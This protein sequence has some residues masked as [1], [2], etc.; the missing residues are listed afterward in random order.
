MDLA[1][2]PTT[3][4]LR[5]I[6]TFGSHEI[7]H[8]RLEE[9]AAERPS[10]RVGD[11]P[12]TEAQVRRILES[13][14]ISTTAAERAQDLGLANDELR[15]LVRH[16]QRV[17]LA[18]EEL[19]R[20][21]NTRSLRP[22][23]AEVEEYY[24]SNRNDYRSQSELDLEMIRFPFTPESLEETNRRA[25]RTLD[26]IHSNQPDLGDASH[27]HLNNTEGSGTYS[28]ATLTPRHLAGYGPA[29]GRAI[30][31]LRI[32]EVSGLIRQDN[33]FWIIKVTAKRPTRQLEFGEVRDL[34]RRRLGQRRVD[35][36][37]ATATRF[38]E[39][40]AATGC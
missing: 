5:T 4:P 39:E 1:L 9:L 28:T 25:R 40:I 3:D 22:T 15:S 31:S 34:V 36:I 18:T 29:V 30:Q 26:T 17:I 35:E 20:R 21:V 32:G 24:E 10:S 13:T 14:A 11:R 38:L 33:D 23:D 2:D 8:E 19:S 16:H 7:T 37:R 27:R 12:L 6:A